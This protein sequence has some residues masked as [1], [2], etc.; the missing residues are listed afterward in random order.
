MRVLMRRY[1]PPAVIINEQGD[2]LYFHDDTSPYLHPAEGA[3]SFNILKMIIPEL[4]M[5]L[6]TGIRQIMNQRQDTIQDVV[7][8]Q[9]GDMAHVVRIVLTP[10]RQVAQT[11][12]LTLIMFEEVVEDPPMPHTTK[13]ED[14]DVPE[15]E[16]DKRISEL[17]QELRTAREYL[18]TTIEEL[19]TS[20]EELKSANEELQSSNE[21]FQSTNE[22]LETTKEELQSVNEELITVNAELNAKIESLTDAN[23]DQKNLMDNMDVGLIFLSDDLRVRLFNPIASELINL[24]PD[25]V[26]RPVRHFAANF[27]YSHF[28]RDCERVLDTLESLTLEIRGYDDS[29]YAMR[30]RPYYT[31]DDDIGG[32]VITFADITK[33]K[34]FQQQLTT[35]S[36]IYRN[37]LNHLPE[38]AV[39]VFDFDL[40]YMLVG[41]EALE[42]AGFSAEGL[43]NKTLFDVLPEDRATTLDSY[44]RSAL[45]GERNEYIREFNGRLYRNITAPVMRDDGTVLAGMVIAIEIQQDETDD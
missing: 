9:H 32:L 10:L 20:N 5:S 29:W 11:E 12:R 41:G 37:L 6:S 44:Y 18:Q 24:M 21:E 28:V 45:N 39:L 17:E 7:R 38:T 40:R 33:Q 15:D 3:A 8:F 35:R 34:V 42:D 1:T 27:D 16:K 4:R 25:D 43:L 13:P 26:G 36:E 22:E 14:E 2:I 23:N 19:E 31:L 30:L